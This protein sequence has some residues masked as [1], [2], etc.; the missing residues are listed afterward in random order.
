MNRPLVTVAIPSYN[1]AKYISQTI[2]S[3]LDQTF[4]DFEILI[5]DDVSTDNSIEIIKSFNDPRIRIISLAEN[6]GVCAVSNI[7]IQNANSK[8]IAL[9]ASDDI[10]EK[11]KLEKQVRF[12]EENPNFGAVFSGMTIIDENGK[13]NEKK[14][15]KYTKV[16]E[17]ENRCRFE[18]LNYFFHNANCIAATSLLAN[19]LA[20]KTVGGF[21]DK[22]TQAHD[23]DLWVRLCLSGYEIHIIHEKLLQYRERNNCRN[24]S[25]NTADTRIRLLFDNEKILNNFLKISSPADFTKIFPTSSA[26]SMKKFLPKEEKIIISYLVLQE[27]HKNSKSI[28]HM[29]FATTLIYEILKEDLAMEILNKNFGFNLKEYKKFITQNPLGQLLEENKCSIKKGFSKKLKS[30]F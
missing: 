3:I 19:T 15:R 30:L 10:M 28:Y 16:F 1:H 5:I 22:I 23:L 26:A 9:I 6:Q 11:T 12:L 8:Y 7:C 2:Q 24:L 25:S 18:W 13:I 27:A 17:K 21:D 20:L 14:T 4:Q 29:Q